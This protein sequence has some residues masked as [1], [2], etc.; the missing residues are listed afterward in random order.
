MPQPVNQP[1]ATLVKLMQPQK[2]AISSLKP[3]EVKKLI[4]QQYGVDLSYK[5]VWG[6]L[7][8]LTKQDELINDESFEQIEGYLTQLAAKNP[9]SH[10]NVERAGDRFERAFFCPSYARNV[11][12][13][14]F[15]VIVNDACHVHSHHAGTILAANVLDGE[16]HVLPIAIAVVPSECEQEWTYFYHHLKLSVLHLDEEHVVNIYDSEGIRNAQR[17]VL[18]NV[19]ES[20]CMLHLEQNVQSKFSVHWNPTIQQLVKATTRKAADDIFMT[21][22]NANAALYDYLQQANP[23]T[24]TSAFVP[25]PRYGIH[26]SNSAEAMHDMY[27]DL[28]NGSYLDIFVKWVDQVSQLRKKRSEMCKDVKTEDSLAHR[29]FHS[30]LQEARKRECWIASGEL[31]V[32]SVKNEQKTDAHV[33]YLKKK[34]C[35][36]GLFQEYGKPCL[37]AARAIIELKKHYLDFFHKAFLVENMQAMYQVEPKKIE[38]EREREKTEGK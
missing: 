17:A 20:L 12:D 34:V 15:P 35:S 16:R 19:C 32:V 22:R 1:V 36:C 4:V 13:Y 21:I 14:C 10:F 27:K 26:T 38:R 23:K 3:S 30:L 2:D 24:Y 37:H 6:A 9:G 8:K 18:P 29:E 5:A 7:G 25:Q 11:L 33:V 31:Q 28:R